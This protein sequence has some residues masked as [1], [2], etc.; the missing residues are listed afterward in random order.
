MKK[1]RICG[2]LMGYY[3]FIFLSPCS[4]AGTTSG[5]VSGTDSGAFTISANVAAE[6]CTIDS[7]SSI[8]DLGDLYAIN[9]TGKGTYK[10]FSLVLSNC[11][12]GTTGVTATFTGTADTLAPAWYYQNTGTAT[13]IG[14]ELAS[15]GGNSGLGNGSTMTVSV[16][17]S[18]KATFNLSTRINREGTPTPGTV[19]AIINITY[20]YS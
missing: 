16:D 9:I 2:I 15:A 10:N 4:L 7:S 6:P 8:Q 11:G 14:I 13:G 12:A 20:T 17:S 18:R 5:T 19:Q 1:T 3:S